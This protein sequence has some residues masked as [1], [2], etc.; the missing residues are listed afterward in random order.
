[1]HRPLGNVAPNL[2]QS[3]VEDAFAAA[4]LVIERQDVIGTEWRE[5]T[6]ERTNV[7][8]RALLRLARLRRQQQAIERAIGADIY[9]HVQAN[10]LWEVNQFLGKLQPVVYPKHGFRFTPLSDHDHAVAGPWGTWGEKKK[11]ALTP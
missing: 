9:G 2:I 10:L 3:H 1:M 11:A 8:S 6:E 7:V 5:Y 4:G